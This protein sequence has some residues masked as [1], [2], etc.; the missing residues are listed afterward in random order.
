MAAARQRVASAEQYADGV[1]AGDRAMLARAITLIESAKGEHAD[2]AQQLLQRL[3]PHTGNAL[4]ARHHRRA[5]RR[6]VDHDRPAR[7]EPGGAGAPDRGA[8]RRPDLDALGRLDPRRQD[9]HDAPLPEPLSLHPALA[10]L[11]HAGRRR[12]QD[13]RGDDAGGG[14]GLRRRDR[15]DRGRRPVRGGGGGPGRFLPRAAARRRGRRPAGHQARHHGDRRHDR[16]HQ[17]RRRQRGARAD[18]RWRSIRARCR[19]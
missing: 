5:G 10:H 18:G 7:H 6:Q 9:A 8:G 1:L 2:L 11:G 19:Y 14:G 4:R 15:G 17:G 16:R 12:A 13:P 3:L